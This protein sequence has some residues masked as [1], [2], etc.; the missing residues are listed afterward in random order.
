MCGRAVK[1]FVV[2]QRHSRTIFG[3][4]AGDVL[5]AV[6]LAFKI[7]DLRVNCLAAA[8]KANLILDEPAFNVKMLLRSCRAQFIV[9]GKKKCDRAGAKPRESLIGAAR[10]NNRNARPQHNAG[11]IRFRQIPQQLRQHIAG[12]YV[13]YDEDVRQPRNR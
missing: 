13:G 2:D 8:N 6:D 5:K 1:L 10:E 4:K 7:T 9:P 11:H 12:F 3:P